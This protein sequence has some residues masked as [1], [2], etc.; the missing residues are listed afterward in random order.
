MC[1]RASWMVVVAVLLVGCAAP[2]QRPAEQ[3]AAPPSSEAAQPSEPAAATTPA[4]ARTSGNCTWVNGYRRKD[5]TY[6][7]GHQRCL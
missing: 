1:S 5:G 3:A 2:M 7:K 6:V 4:A